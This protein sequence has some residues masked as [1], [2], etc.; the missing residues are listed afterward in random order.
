ML[1]PRVISGVE[2]RQGDTKWGKEVEGSSASYLG[3]RAKLMTHSSKG[4]LAADAEDLEG[5]QDKGRGGREE[6]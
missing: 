2:A 4:R 3:G 6:K 1:L 5:G